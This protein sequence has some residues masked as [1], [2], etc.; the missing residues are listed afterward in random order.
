MSGLL[1]QILNG[2]SLGSVYALVA[3]GFTMV[4]G[5]IKLVNFAHCDIFMV[6]AYTGYFAV[7][8]LGF[9]FFPALLFSMTVCA[10]LGVLI[11]RVAY[12]PLRNSAKETL[13]VTAIAIEL[14]L[15]NLIKADFVAGPNILS[16]PAVIET[17][18]YTVGGVSFSNL[19]LIS[20]GIVILMCAALQILIN[21]TNVGRAMRATAYD[22]DAAALMGIDIDRIIALTFAIGSALAAVSGVLV[23][24]MYPKLEPTM[25]VLLGMKSFVAA[26]VGGIGIIPGAMLG[27]VLIGLIEI[28]SKVYISS[29]FSDA[30]VFLILI[31]ILLVKPT[32]LLGKKQSVKV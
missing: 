13:L 7:N 15:Q 32:G 2:V 5:I 26:V 6:G 30:I 3:I 14:V 12:R 25:G 18:T 16:F 1:Q 24:L 8:T 11:E 23:G 27:G 19:Q 9:G 31:I 22:R 29:S 21:R 17:K 28:L 10:V 20:L 4:Y